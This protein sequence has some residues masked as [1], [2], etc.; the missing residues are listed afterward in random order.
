[1]KVVASYVTVNIKMAGIILVVIIN[2]IGARI[3]DSIGTSIISGNS[4][5]S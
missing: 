2:V 4:Y 5:Y 1:M 3:T